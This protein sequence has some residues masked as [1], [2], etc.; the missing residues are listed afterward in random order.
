MEG[1]Q[2][3]GW[4]LVG[5]TDV[6]P[7]W[8]PP[9]EQEAADVRGG[10]FFWSTDAALRFRS[11]SDAAAFLLGADAA[12]CEG[13]DV[14]AMLGVEGTNLAIL[15]AHCEALNGREGRFALEGPTGFVQCRVEPSHAGD[16][17]VIGTF[18]LALPDDDEPLA[19]RRVEELVV[20]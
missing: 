7:W 13:Q 12:W 17:R 9:F 15:E 6:E 14:L 18:C 4:E 11:V 10:T 16:G 5:I 19:A 2:M 3:R 20:V 1:E 8:V